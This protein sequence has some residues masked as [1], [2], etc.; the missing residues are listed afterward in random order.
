MKKTT[1]GAW[2]IHHANKLSSTN[3]AADFDQINFAGKCGTMLS[4]LT[5]STQ[6]SLDTPKVDALAKT[7]G[8]S[9]RTELPAILAELHKQRLINQGASGIDIL[10]L[11]TAKTLEHTAE[12][13]EGLSPSSIE[14]ASIALS[15]KASEL[16]IEQSVLNPFIEDTCELSKEETTELIQA[17]EQIGF[18]DAEAISG[19]SKIFFNGN[20]FRKDDA[21][22]MAA[23]VA[24]LKSDDALKVIAFNEELGK[25]GCL[26]LARAMEVLGK[27]L[28]EKLH[29]IGAYDVNRVGND[30]GQYCFV[31]RPAAFK[32]FSDS[33]VDDAFDLAKAFVASLTYG[34][35]MS[36]YGRGKITMIKRLMQKLINGGW[37]GPATAI[38]HDY[39]VLELKRVVEVQ[40][41]TGGMFNMRLL[42]REVG[43]IALQVIVEGEASTTFAAQFPGADVT[44]YQ[45]PESTRIFQRKTLAAPMKKQ[46]SALLNQLRT[47]KLSS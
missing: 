5:T 30:R 8:V 10:G 27:S 31:T 2:I 34:M 28:F 9:V 40:P 23:V 7:A 29:A 21:A 37:V 35:T 43:E 45:A 20:L 41:E 36:A 39:K 16:P 15:E 6:S 38:G 19:S 25:C 13:F 11:T 4:A 17:A 3:A 44:T 14:E 47:G 22:K 42:K 33:V 26:V 12:I 24:S 46:I 18:V 32:K 1:K